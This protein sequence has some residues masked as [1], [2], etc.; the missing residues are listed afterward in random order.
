MITYLCNLNHPNMLSLQSLRSETPAV[1]ATSPAPKMSNKYTFVP[2]IEILENFDRE[3]WKVYSAK[4]LG[5]SQYATHEIRLRNGQLPQV[6]DSLVEAV[7][8]NSHNGMSTFS[9]SAGLYRLVCS[10]GLTVPTS[11]ADSITVKHMRVDLGSVRQITD[12]FADR[13]PL[14]Q[15]SVGRMENS[16]LNQERTM[17]M[18]NKAKLIR[19]EKGSMP[20]HINVEDLL[21]PER[22]GDKGNSVWKIFNV[23]QEKFVRGGV[24][25]TSKNGRNVSMKE[26]KNFQTINKIN[27]SLWELA[28]SYCG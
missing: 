17:D 20:S 2:T 19:W 18:L 14:I 13:L 1:F 6:G 8:R 15:S 22:D 26:L 10:N 5:G 24:R 7:I 11:V 23:I 25:Y 3:G 27:T 4:Q 21:R 28:D 16:F 9:V 12:E